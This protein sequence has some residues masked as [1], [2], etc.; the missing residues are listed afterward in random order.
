M[1][2]LLRRAQVAN[3]Q[4][5]ASIQPFCL[6]FTGE[7]QATPDEECFMQVAWQTS[8]RELLG[9]HNAISAQRMLAECCVALK[10]RRGRRDPPEEQ[11]QDRR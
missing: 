3:A 7:V 4:E 6:C 10:A 1:S 8:Y 9:E 2:P 11:E 5:A